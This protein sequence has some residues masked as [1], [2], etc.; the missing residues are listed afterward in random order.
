[1]REREMSAIDNNE[2]TGILI[3]KRPRGVTIENVEYRA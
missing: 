3:K 1:M 2:E